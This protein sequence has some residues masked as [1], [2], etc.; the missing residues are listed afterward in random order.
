MTQNF[1]EFF[2]FNNVGKLNQ[3]NFPKYME[4]FFPDGVVRGEG[5]ELSVYA[6]STGMKV[7]IRPGVCYVH[8]HRASNP[9]AEVELP[10]E[11]AD[12]TYSRIDLVVARA[13]YDIAP[14]SYMCL[15]VKKGA[16]SANPAPPLVEKTAGVIWEIPLAQVLVGAGV[17]TISSGAVTDRRIWSVLP[18]ERGGTNAM[19]AS[20]ALSNVFGGGLLSI[21]RGGTNAGSPA[22][23]RTNL[24]LG[25][26]AVKNVGEETVQCAFTGTSLTVPVTGLPAGGL[27]FIEP[28]QASRAAFYAADV[29]YSS[30]AAGSLTLVATTN[31]GTISVVVGWI[32]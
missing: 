9:T 31:P 27:V 15:A 19:N 3:E 26:A 29:R 4:P 24:G 6:N 14:N 25:N 11:P 21:E 23:A 12:A 32:G 20:D 13:V 30:H 7:M 5:Q 28:A 2:F 18:I 22:G 17:Q 8:T 16:P 10:I 1:T